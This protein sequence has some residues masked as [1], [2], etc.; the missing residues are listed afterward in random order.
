MPNVKLSLATL[1][2]PQKIELAQAA[3]RIH[4]G[5][6]RAGAAGE[7]PRRGG[8]VRIEINRIDGKKH[9]NL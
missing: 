8:A 1:T 2:I 6:E 5:L 9:G 4:R 7:R 3:H